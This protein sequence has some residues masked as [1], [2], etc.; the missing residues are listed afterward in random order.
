MAGT[1]IVIGENVGGY[2]DAEIDALLLAKEDALGFT[3]ED[4]AN[5]GNAN[6]YAELDGSG[7]VP[8]AQLPSYVDDVLEYANFAALP[9]EGETGKSYVTIDDN[10]QWRWSGTQYVQISPSVA[11]GETSETAYRGDRGKGAYD[12][13]Q[14]AHDKTLVGLGNVDNTADLDKP[15][16]DDTQ[17]ALDAKMANLADDSTPQLGGELDAQAHSIGFTLQTATGDGAT[18]IDW[19]LG[20][21]FALLLAAASAPE[22]LT[23]IAPS[24]SCSLL[25]KLK[26]HSTGGQTVTFHASVKWVGG[27]APTLSTGNNAED[28]V[29][30][31]WDGTSYYATCGIGFA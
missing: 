25:L 4:V 26:Q 13:S 28:I 18:T 20:N 29:S 6:G 16:S 24:K 11:L 21:K 5:K 22:V 12:H 1:D 7:K 3:P 14:L 27:V 10:K 17:T 2:S 15:I 19:R 31:F 30:L 8:T 23:F 9:A